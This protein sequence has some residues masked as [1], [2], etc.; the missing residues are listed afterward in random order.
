MLNR[1]SRLDLGR[2]G[3]VRLEALGDSSCVERLR[4]AFLASTIE[5]SVFLSSTTSSSFL[6]LI[7]ALE[8]CARGS[9]AIWCIGSGTRLFVSTDSFDSSLEAADRFFLIFFL[10]VEDLGWFRFGFL[11]TR[12]II[13]GDTSVSPKDI[14][15]SSILCDGGDASVNIG[16]LVVF[17]TV[18]VLRTGTDLPVALPVALKDCASDSIVDVS[19]ETEESASNRLEEKESITLE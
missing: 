9:F 19:T 16:I 5:S 17:A 4:E 11:T 15:S 18:R 13:P 3:S 1:K 8:L 14:L 10:G 12:R 2:L 6:L 7:K